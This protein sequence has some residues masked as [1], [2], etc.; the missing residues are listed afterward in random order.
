[1]LSIKIIYRTDNFFELGAESLSV[2][3]LI[4][5]VSRTY[6]VEVPINHFYN[7]P[8]LANLI[9]IINQEHTE[10]YIYIN[11]CIRKSNLLIEKIENKSTNQ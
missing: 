2:A 6:F 3:Q 4:F 11:N 5:H 9:R 1:M 8:T 10:E 7:E